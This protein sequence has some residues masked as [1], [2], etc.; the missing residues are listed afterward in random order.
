MVAG[1]PAFGLV[2]VSN[3]TTSSQEDHDGG[4]ERNGERDLFFLVGPLCSV[5]IKGCTSLGEADAHKARK[6]RWHR[7]NGCFPLVERLFAHVDRACLARNKGYEIF[8]QSRHIR[9]RPRDGKARSDFCNDCVN[10]VQ[11]LP[12]LRSRG[13]SMFSM[14]PESFLFPVSR[15]RVVLECSAGHKAHPCGAAA[16]SGSP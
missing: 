8:S 5:S 14:I 1:K 10:D 9:S 4:G 6:R 2:A 11:F 16:W 12:Q 7:A 15:G 13:F 3:A